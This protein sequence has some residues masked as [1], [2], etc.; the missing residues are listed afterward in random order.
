MTFAFNDERLNPHVSDNLFHF[1][2][3][4]GADVVQA[5]ASESQE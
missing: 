2:I 1:T 3:P 4:Q 5:V